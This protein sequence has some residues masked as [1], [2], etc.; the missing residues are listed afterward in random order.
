[1]R[2][3]RERIER[4]DGAYVRGMACAFNRRGWDVAAMN[5]RGCSGEP[6]RLLRSYHS[7]AT[8]DLLHIVRHV[9]RAGCDRVVWSASAWAA[10]WS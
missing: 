2:Y 10:T 5:F 7:G 9:K 1:M 4:E 6:N 3:I 8:D